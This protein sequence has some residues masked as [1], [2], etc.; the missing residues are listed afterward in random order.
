MAPQ[1][2]DTARAGMGAVFIGAGDIGHC[3]T[4]AD[5][6]VG[7]LIEKQRGNVFT[8]GDNAYPVGS[9]DDFMNC[10][11]PAWGEF[12]DRTFPTPGNHGYMTE[13]AEGYFTYF[14]DRARAGYYAFQRG[15][16]R[17]YSLNSEVIDEEQ[18]DWLRAD[19]AANPR[20][21]V[22]AY[23]HQPLFSSRA[24]GGVE[25]VR[26]FW[27]ILYKHRADVILSGHAHSYE[28][29]KKQDPNGVRDK[30]GIRLFVVGTGGAP[31]KPFGD[32]IAA[33][34]KVRQSETWGA[35]KMRLHSTGYTWEFKRAAG[36]RGFE[37][38]GTARCR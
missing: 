2:T 32:T 10:Y 22:L 27:D 24:E 19:L 15:G 35:L 6:K 9:L 33:N 18:L 8:L 36:E 30:L 14:G 25:T 26:P 34:S 1:L 38:A 37:D 7:N 11:D 13:D 21:C 28:R 16:W 12:K 4:T 31:L 5:T 23:F 29:F 3:R 20:L 17:I